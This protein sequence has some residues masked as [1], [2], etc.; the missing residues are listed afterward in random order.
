VYVDLSYVVPSAGTITSFSFASDSSN[1]GDELDF[2]VLHRLGDSVSYT[3]VGKTGLV[4]LKGTGLET[5]STRI[6]VDGP[7]QGQ[8]YLGLW[9]PGVLNN[10]AHRGGDTIFGGDA[11]ADPS[12]GATI[13]LPNGGPLEDLNESANLVTLG[14]GPLPTSK[15]QCKHGGWRAFGSMFKN[16]GDCTSFVATRGKNPPSGS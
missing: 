16:Q 13:D 10:C 15:A 12:T 1:K 5:F 14:K 6:A 2:L 3:V 8:A 11:A 4:T 9:T 7:D